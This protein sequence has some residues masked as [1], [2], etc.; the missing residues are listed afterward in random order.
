MSVN[1]L[2]IGWDCSPAAALRNL[3]LRD[4]ALPFDWVVS[5]ISALQN[6]FETNFENFHKNLVLN[7]N[8]TRLIDHYGF[9]FPHDYPLSH[10]K[11]FENNNIGEGVFGEENGK[12]I[13]DNWSNYYDIVLD[14]YNRRIE[15]F[16]N[17]INDTK[18]IIVLC[19]YSTKDVL[20]LQKLFINYYKL[21]NIYFI[22]SS[23]E[24]FENDNI[25]NINT[26]KNNVWNDVNI[27]NECVDYIIKNKL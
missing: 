17:I 11:D 23:N 15:R 5:N 7:Y 1:F 2:T 6:C 16:K 4:I 13:T 10:M 21:K 12:F 19:R 26:E 8:K 9:Q 14:K 22:N 27:W 20:Q 3:N 18:P 25:K 24:L